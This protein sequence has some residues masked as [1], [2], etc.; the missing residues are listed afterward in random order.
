MS[1][2]FNWID[3]LPP[4]A[5]SSMLLRARLRRHTDATILYRQGELTT[6]FFQVLAGGIRKFVLTE[7][8]W[9][10]LLY[11]YGPGDVVADSSAID[12]DP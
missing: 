11:T 5:R 12:R 4:G 1:S 8:G 2:G 9:E 7:E 3:S 10:V 6:E